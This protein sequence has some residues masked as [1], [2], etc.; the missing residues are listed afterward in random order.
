MVRVIALLMVMTMPASAQLR[1]DWGSNLGTP[2][3]YGGSRDNGWAEHQ[4]RQ[5][6]YSQQL[7]LE[8]IERQ[9]RELE[10]RQ[11]DMMEEQRRLEAD[12]RFRQG[13]PRPS[14][15]TLRRARGSPRLPEGS[16]PVA[17]CPR[18]PGYG[19]PALSG[20]CA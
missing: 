1:Y 16:L 13:W 11:R 18:C 19:L 7:R 5:R 6:E 20:I 8:E 12:R 15:Y 14:P 9:Q 3:S 2:G 17:Y 4:R 10:M